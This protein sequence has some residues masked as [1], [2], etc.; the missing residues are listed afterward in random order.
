MVTASISQR[1]SSQWTVLGTVE[2]TDWSVIQSPAI[3]NSAG[4]AVDSLGLNYKDGWFYSLGA[5]Y[6]YSPKLTLRGGA[7]WELSPISDRNRNVMLP[8]SDRIWGSLGMTYK[9]SSNVSFDLAYSHLFYGDG[10]INQGAALTATS[11]TSIDIVSAGLKYHV[12]GA[13]EQL[14]PLK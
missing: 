12:G 1:L 13:R 7:A 3:V 5:E 2:W 9:Y 14:E 8:D 4:V 6:A 11:E 10:D